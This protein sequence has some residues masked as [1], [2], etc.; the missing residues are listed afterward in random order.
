MVGAGFC[1]IFGAAYSMNVRESSTS[2]LATTAAAVYDASI[3]AKYRSLPC[4]GPEMA[5]ALELK[6]GEMTGY[7]S[8]S[9]GYPSNMQPAL[10]YA[11]DAKIAGADAAWKLFAGRSVQPDYGTGAQFAIVPRTAP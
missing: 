4:A 1:W 5:A 3:E 11:V 2:P 8:S 10:A 7:S 6:A 9:A